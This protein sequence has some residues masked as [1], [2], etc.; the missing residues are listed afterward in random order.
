[1]FKPWLQN[2]YSTHVYSIQ[3]LMVNPLHQS[4][5]V[6]QFDREVTVTILNCLL[7]LLLILWEIHLVNYNFIT[8]IYADLGESSWINAIFI[9]IFSCHLD[10]FLYLN[11]SF[12]DNYIRIYNYSLVSFLLAHFL[13]GY[14]LF[15]WLSLRSFYI[16]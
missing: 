16:L 9:H 5:V 4:L 2:N 7:H 13:S 10:Y 3:L 8:I 12:S 14:P 6:V 15:Y 11:E 1:M